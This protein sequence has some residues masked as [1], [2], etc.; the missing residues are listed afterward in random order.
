MPSLFSCLDLT[1]QLHNLSKALPEER[2]LLPSYNLQALLRHVF[3]IL[4]VV[5]QFEIVISTNLLKLVKINLMW[6][7]L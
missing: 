1:P 5:K 7:S 4:I 2:V 6:Q 3:I